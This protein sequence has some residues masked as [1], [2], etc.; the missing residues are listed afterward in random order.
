MY[1]FLRYLSCPTII[2]VSL[3][4][5][6]DASGFLQAQGLIMSVH[7]AQRFYLLRADRTVWGRGSYLSRSIL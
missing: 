3:G 2:V 1:D 6:M 4:W 7:T 5:E